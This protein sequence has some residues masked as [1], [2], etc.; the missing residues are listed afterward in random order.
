MRIQSDEYEEWKKAVNED[1]EAI[2][3]MLMNI[4]KEYLYYMVT[5]PPHVIVQ[6]F[7][8]T[9]YSFLEGMGLEE[10]QIRKIFEAG[11]QYAKENM[12]KVR[13]ELALLG[14]PI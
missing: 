3:R 12:E 10:E 13:Y 6:S 1:I 8:L 4:V 14:I 9:V 2:S 7:I 11:Y 5:L